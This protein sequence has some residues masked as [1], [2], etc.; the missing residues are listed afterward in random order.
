MTWKGWE[1]EVVAQFGVPSWNLSGENQETQKAYS[2]ATNFCI[3]CL[4]YNFCLK[5]KRGSPAGSFE[6]TFLREEG[7]FAPNIQTSVV[8]CCGLGKELK[9]PQYAWYFFNC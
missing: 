9:I 1:K 6:T 2:P 4:T 7:L 8:L 5:A 3:E